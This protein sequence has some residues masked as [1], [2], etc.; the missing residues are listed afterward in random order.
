MGNFKHGYARP[1]KVEKLHNLW[2]DILKRCNNHPDYKGRGISVCQ[3]WQ[4]YVP[5]RTWALS[6]GY[7]EGLSI[8]RIDNDGG[9]S[10]ENCR[11]TTMKEQSRN[12]RTTRYITH[13]G[14]TKC[15]AAW[16]EDNGIDV[17]KLHYRLKHG[18]GM[19]KALKN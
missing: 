8:D 3:E 4:E 6:N 10:P 7:K 1:G 18:W 16:A 13:N 9:Y 5:F 2:R 14:E 11:F 17:S 15:L 12:R 19:D